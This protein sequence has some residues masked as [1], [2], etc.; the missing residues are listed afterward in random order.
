MVPLKDYVWAALKDLYLIKQ[1]K[2]K[3][4]NTPCFFVFEKTRNI[5][6]NKN[7]E[8]MFFLYLTQRW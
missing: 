4:K 6:T 7:M 2:T 5:Q 1:K 8:E 3:N